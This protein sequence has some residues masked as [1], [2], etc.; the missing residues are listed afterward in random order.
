M[1]EQWGA[2]LRRY[3][4]R[5]GFTQE[6]LADVAGVSIRTI[7]R[8]E[9]GHRPQAHGPSVKRVAQALGLT[10]DE[11]EQLRAMAADPAA[12]Q[13]PGAGRAVAPPRQLPLDPEPFAGR[14]AELGELTAKLAGTAR[15]IVVV[16][17][18]R[19]VGKTFLV[20]RWAAGHSAQFP[21]GQ[22]Y[23][24]LRG[25]G[26]NAGAQAPADVL[27]QF[28]FALGFTPQEVPGDVEARAALYRGAV[29]G[30]RLLV[31]LDNA[32]DSQQVQPLLPR[33]PGCA[34]VVTSRHRLNGLVIGSGAE[35]LTLG[36]MPDTEARE[37]LAAAIGPRRASADGAD[38]L[39]G[40]CRGLP[41]VLGA[42]A[43]RAAAHPD[44]GLR[45]LTEELREFVAS[46][47]ANHDRTSGLA[48]ILGEHHPDVEL[49]ELA[50]RLVQQAHQLNELGRPE[51]ALS[52]ITDAEA[53][54]RQLDRQTPG[55]YR[56]GP[57]AECLVT[58]SLQLL[59]LGFGEEAVKASAEAVQLR[60]PHDDE[61]G[62]PG[63]PTAAV[64][65]M[66]AG[67]LGNHAVLLCTTGRQD[68]ALAA[69]T[70]V[71]ELRRRFAT[72]RKAGRTV[73]SR[74]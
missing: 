60:R 30:K 68:E 5:A 42:V 25:F 1:T 13:Q 50:S 38:E 47:P 67:S 57:L 43:A 58:K 7:R 12:E 71:V 59:D 44:R 39:L 4:T 33:S 55:F 35:S 16:D 37:I 74:G 51:D 26:T 31:V 20:L 28:L 49:F 66:L 54:Y 32:R 65:R 46:S 56:A 52:A 17:G 27:S 61:R 15:G 73:S 11:C 23:A 41:L 10:T 3:R 22:L 72:A 69:L 8:W 63:V 24:G 70:E 62:Q 64:L 19:G 45:E 21:D 6:H 9:T 40:F 36:P 53:V 14:A 29:A 2:L 34:V 48:A 18:P